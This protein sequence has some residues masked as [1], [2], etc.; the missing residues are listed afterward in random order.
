MTKPTDIRVVGA[1][2]HLIPLHLRVP[3]KFG[4]ET[5]TSM[6]CA[7]VKLTVRSR[8]GREAEGWGETPLSAAWAW[9][10]A[11]GVGERSDAMESFCRCLT[12]A[13][14]SFGESGHPMEVGQAFI[15]R[16]LDQ[17]LDVFNGQRKCHPGR[18]TGGDSG[19]RSGGEAMPHLAALICCSA[20]DIAVHD[21]FGNLVNRPTYQTYTAQ[22]MN[23]DLGCY[24]E[25]ATDSGISFTSRYPAD[26]FVPQP[27]TRLPAWHLVGGVDAL[28][29][30][31]LN[32]SEPNDGY[33]VTLEG[34]IT[35]DSLK[36]LKI[37]LRGNDTA[38]DY[39]RIV[40]IGQIAQRAG[41]RWLTADFNCTVTD[42]AYVNQILDRL[43]SEQP[44]TYGM[45]LYVEQ[46]FPYDL[47][48][49]PIDV[50]SVASRKPL[51][52]DESAHDWTYVKRGREL[53]W[54]GVALKT[55]KTQTGAL[56]SM[57]WA[58]A[59][60]MALMVQDLTNPALA[61]IPHAL[62]AQHAGTIYG[63]ETNAVQFWPQASK[64]QEK[65]HPGL[66]NRTGG[67][68]DLSTV[69]ENGFG[70]ARETSP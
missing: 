41:V 16:V 24:L 10:S 12:K 7:R 44:R 19:G 48:A 59:H 55:C 70:Y 69:T 47:D 52:M 60:G 14:E 1:E 46:P 5:V 25:P 31:G 65:I 35:R 13:W 2:L 17:H 49:H 45:L 36:A 27:P 50:H 3:L 43:K 57:C 39:D 53:G 28:D 34:W 30:S 9:P 58:K 56:L 6:T 51:L 54:N 8:D 42:P 61:I 20:F 29:S 11:I 63:V 33:P 62:L 22:F 68:V 4:K 66:Y 32:G 18:D 67:V 26:F 38:W 21:A 64:D 23:H 40:R 15:G 37:K